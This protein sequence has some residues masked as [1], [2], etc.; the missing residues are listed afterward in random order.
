MSANNGKED[1]GGTI[2][3]FNFSDSKKEEQ[4]KYYV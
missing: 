1:W 3:N 2:Q 4:K